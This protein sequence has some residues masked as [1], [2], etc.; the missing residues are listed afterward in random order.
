MCVAPV[1]AAY[2]CYGLHHSLP[3]ITCIWEP[4]APMLWILK[5]LLQCSQLCMH[6]CCALGEVKLWSS[7]LAGRTEADFPQRAVAKHLK[8][9]NVP[10]YNSL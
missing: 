10:H 3:L 4:E 9:A 8:G 5:M 1:P 7:M 6:T 2:G